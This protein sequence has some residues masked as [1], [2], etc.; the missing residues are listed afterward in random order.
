MNKPL[1][2]YSRPHSYRCDE[3][4][5]SLCT[6]SGH[7]HDQSVVLK[8]GIF[9]YHRKKLLLWTKHGDDGLQE[10][11]FFWWI[12]TS[13]HILENS[14]HIFSSYNVSIL[15]F[16]KMI[17]RYTKTFNKKGYTLNSENVAQNFVRLARHFLPATFLRRQ[18]SK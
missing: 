2:N 6:Q 4:F 16:Q 14:S 3:I 7:V 11:R 17:N 12:S 8:E 10:W 15:I 18:W 9:Q 5:S 13:V 1:Q